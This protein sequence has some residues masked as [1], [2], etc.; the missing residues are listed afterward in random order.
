[1]KTLKI[2][3]SLVLI[4][5]VSVVVAAILPT[6]PAIGLSVISLAVVPIIGSIKTSAEMKIERHAVY[7][8][9]KAIMDKARDEKRALTP[10]EQT[11]YDKL[12]RQL[13]E[14]EADIKRVEKD[15]RRALEMAGGVMQQ[16]NKEKEDKELSKFSFMRV[17]RSLASGL[18]PEQI[19]GLEGEM[20]KEAIK[21]ARE[22][23]IVMKG[24]GV[25][26]II[27]KR[28]ATATGQTSATGDQGGVMVPTLKVGFIEALINKM[29]TRGLGIQT[30]TGLIG[31]IDI[32]KKSTTL[33]AAWE[34]E[35]TESDETNYAFAKL[36]MAPRR[37]AA[38]TA[39]SKQLMMQASD[40]VEAMVIRDLQMAIAQKVEN[41]IINGTGSA[42]N[43]PT[44]ILQTS[45]IGSV[46][47]G[48]T[49][50][51]LTWE[52]ITKL[53]REIGVD[54]ADLGAMAY[55]TNAKIR[56]QLKNTKKD[57]G[58]G[59][60]LLGDENVLNGYPIA[61]T[62]LVP[63]NLTKSTGENLSAL[64][65]GVWSEYV[66]CQWGGIDIVVDP[67]SKKKNGLVEVSADSFWDGGCRHA[68]SFSAVVDAT[69]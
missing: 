1:M 64:I 47:I 5:L 52:H 59:L 8:K 10:E 2:F 63:S 23:G 27:L 25:P 62:N 37:L 50:G 68:E 32:P 4:L 67:Y 30:L 19:D 54:N 21:E 13:D 36:S 56:Q 18:A 39:F 49:G 51:A 41:A 40:D 16:R 26:M 22:S 69:S 33:S 46:A 11:E 42:N 35:V 9:A 58:S 53:E 6:D 15:E 48:A 17:L 24:F 45:G 28:S 20:H 61:F 14:M 3:V 7:E 38:W 44:G 43:Q 60:F 31:N 34:G 12:D 57:S 55:L 65:L 66:L 29:V